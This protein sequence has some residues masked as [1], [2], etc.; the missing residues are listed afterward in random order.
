GFAV[1]MLGLL[2]TPSSSATFEAVISAY[3]APAIAA[4]MIGAT[5]NS[6]TSHRAAGPANQATP[7]ERAGLTEVL[8]TGM[9]TRWIRVRPRP[10]AIGAK[11]FGARSSVAPRM[12]E[13]K[14]AV[15]TTSITKQAS[16][17]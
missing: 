16:S 14:T 1:P 5:K 8:V 10:M 6:H 9:D 2:P 7:R 11:P 17:E 12:I 3:V 13:R 4:P 15:S